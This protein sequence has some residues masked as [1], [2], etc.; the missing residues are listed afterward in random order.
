MSISKHVIRIAASAALVAALAA[1]AFA[2]PRVIHDPN[3]PASKGLIHRMTTETARDAEVA[4]D[5]ANRIFGESTGN[6]QIPNINLGSGPKSEAEIQAVLAMLAQRKAEIDAL[7]THKQNEIYAIKTIVNVKVAALEMRRALEEEPIY[8]PRPTR[9]VAA[10][11]NLVRETNEMSRNT[12]L[13]EER[14]V[15]APLN[16]EVRR[17]RESVV[18]LSRFFQLASRTGYRMAE[19]TILSEHLHARVGQVLRMAEAERDWSY[20]EERIVRM[21]Q[22][23]SQETRMFTERALQIDGE[24]E[25]SGRPRSVDIKRELGHLYNQINRR[26]DALAYGIDGNHSHSFPENVKMA[27]AKAEETLEEL[28]YAFGPAYSPAL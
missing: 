18:H 6:I 16:A 11:R 14:G 1:P 2:R 20:R 4:A 28:D 9:S 21:L 15:F 13:W 22:E 7:F 12:T 26:A 3:A 8:S 25:R 24:I 10:F 27:F 17:V 19:V 5:I 23:L